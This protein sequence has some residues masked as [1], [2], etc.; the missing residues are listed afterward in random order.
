MIC[1]PG[2]DLFIADWLSRQNNKD[3]EIAGMDIK[4]N[5]IYMTTDIPNC[6][7]SQEIQQATAND[8]HHNC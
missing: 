5:A 8:D 2:L 6:M 3:E 4:I 1:K 7:N